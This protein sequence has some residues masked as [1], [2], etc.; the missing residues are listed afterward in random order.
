MRKKEEQ[1]MNWQETK[2]KPTGA[3]LHDEFQEGVRFIVMRGPSSL[4]AY[5]G[6][7]TEHPLAGF[8][9]DDLPSIEAHGGLTYSGGGDELRPK[10]FYWY[11][12]D[13]G[14]SGDKSFHH[15]DY[16]P[17]LRGLGEKGWLVEDVV[18]DSWSAIY[19]FTRLMKL[20]ELIAG[21]YRV[22]RVE[23]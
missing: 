10:G 1:K 15:D 11:G 8:H 9:Y 6:I 19:E 3:I 21:R 16:P 7:P 23:K 20:A 2:D 12:W 13:Y 14:H 5:L 17:M 4:C 22:E 18:K